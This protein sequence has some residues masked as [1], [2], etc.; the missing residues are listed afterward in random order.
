MKK[1]L[2]IVAIAA[3]MTACNNSSEEK[4][5]TVDTTK[6]ETPVMDAKMATD[7]TTKMMVDT[8]HKMTDTTTKMK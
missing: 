8:T 3:V 2:A 4:T 5:V 7:T 6:I 1:L